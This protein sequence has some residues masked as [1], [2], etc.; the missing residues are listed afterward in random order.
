MAVFFGAKMITQSFVSSTQNRDSGF[1]QGFK[2]ALTEDPNIKSAMD[3]CFYGALYQNGSFR[4]GMTRL[5]APGYSLLAG[6]GDKRDWL[7]S[8]D[9]CCLLA[10]YK[11]LEILDISY[12]ASTEEN[13][14]NSYKQ[15]YSDAS[16]IDFQ[17][18]YVNGFPVIQS[19][20][21]YTADG[22]YQYQGELIV[23]P[24][25]TADETI[26]LVMF[27]D[28]ASGYGSDAIHQVFDTLEVSP[29]LKIKAEDTNV[30][31][32]NRITVK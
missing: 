29:D 15:S 21:G 24:S 22:L 3:S 28:V 13:L 9:G 11:Q 2:E 4:Y 1:E 32:L 8:N 20:V 30:M 16:M 5:N 23:F 10:A 14:L 7:M 6:E 25:E 27:V 31:G 17:K 19:I 18:Y 12:D 26:R